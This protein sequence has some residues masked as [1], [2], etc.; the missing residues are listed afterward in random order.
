MK[1][2]INFPILV[3]SKDFVVKLNYKYLVSDKRFI[4]TGF[5]K[6]LI[7]DSQGKCYD[8]QK[9]EQDGG[10]DIYYSIALFGYIVPVKPVLSQPVYNIELKEFKDKIIEIVDRHPYKF[11]SI[12][13]S[14][15]LIQEINHCN[16]FSELINLF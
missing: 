3:L 4:S 6:V 11:S 7:I 10:L 9:V 16:T 13:D 8:V 14:E 12:C 2:K 15:T 1:E 5:K